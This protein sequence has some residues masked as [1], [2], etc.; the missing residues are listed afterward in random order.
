MAES[1]KG[2][3]ATGSISKMDAVRAA[4]TRLGGEAKLPQI[5]GFVRDQFG[6][7][8]KLDLIKNYKSSVLKEWREGKGPGGKAPALGSAAKQTTGPK[9]TPPAKQGAAAKPAAEA[10]GNGQSGISLS[11]IQAIKELTQRYG[12]ENLHRLLDLLGR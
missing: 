6:L 12:V 5:Q 8:L 4:L 1:K 10:R 11:D 7:E 3:A 9:A 2:G